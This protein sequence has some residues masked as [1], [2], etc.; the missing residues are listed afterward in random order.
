MWVHAHIATPRPQAWAGDSWGQLRC[1]PQEGSEE[2]LSC[3]LIW[4]DQVGKQMAEA[5][6]VQQGQRLGLPKS[7]F[8]RVRG[9]AHARDPWI[10]WNSFEK[11]SMSTS[12]VSGTI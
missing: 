8:L 9:K 6:E 1:R 12:C 4:T 10:R 5:F 3:T 7:T 11:Y 2:E